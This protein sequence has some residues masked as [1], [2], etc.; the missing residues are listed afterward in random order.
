MALLARL[1]D[2]AADD[3]ALV[4]HA[5]ALVGVGLAQL[6]DRGG[7]LAD[8]LLVDALDPEPGGRLD[9]E[10]DAL[11][12]LHRHRVAEAERE[13]QVAANIRKLRKPDPYK[14]KG[15][16]YQGE[17]VKRKVGKTGK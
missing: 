6:A 17:V 5:F 15:V 1:P 16:R 10:G 9:S 4:T 12:R 13:L 3:F 2:L 8:L 14:G 11:R 7:D